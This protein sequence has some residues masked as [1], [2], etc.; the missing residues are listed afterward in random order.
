MLKIR[1]NYFL[2]INFVYKLIIL[3]RATDNL[4]ENEKINFK[5]E[6]NLKI[7]NIYREIIIRG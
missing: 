6:L 3:S 7:E 4:R 5:N 2:K 1:K